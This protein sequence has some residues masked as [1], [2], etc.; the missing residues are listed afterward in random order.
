MQGGKKRARP[1]PHQ[2]EQ[3]RPTAP[4]VAIPHI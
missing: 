4:I 1:R 3:G 2:V